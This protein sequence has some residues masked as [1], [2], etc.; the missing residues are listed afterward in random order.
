[1]MWMHNAFAKIFTTKGKL[2]YE[3]GSFGFAHPN[4]TLIK[5]KIRI[6]PGLDPNE[7]PLYKEFFLAL[8]QKV[9]QLKAKL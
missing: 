9:K 5:N 7:T 6:N 8:E 1:M 3:R 2:Y 4:L